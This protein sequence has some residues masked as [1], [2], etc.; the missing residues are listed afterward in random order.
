MSDLP[1]ALFYPAGYRP[2]ASPWRDG[3]PLC[4][5]VTRAKVVVGSC[6]G[7]V[8]LGSSFAYATN[9]TA[10]GFVLRAFGFRVWGLCFRV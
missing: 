4:G 6:A 5:L 2:S 10:S 1:T 3:G 8:A 7:A 9:T